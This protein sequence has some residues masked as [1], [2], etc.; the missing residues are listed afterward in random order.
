MEVHYVHSNIFNDNLCPHLLQYVKAR[1]AS[2]KKISQNQKRYFL[3]KYYRFCF[4][5]Y[6]TYANPY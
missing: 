4:S 3:S 2:F 5:S 1:P 6:L